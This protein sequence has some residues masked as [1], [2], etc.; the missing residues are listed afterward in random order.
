LLLCKRKKVGTI[1]SISKHD[2]SSA[3]LKFMDKQG[4][5]KREYDGVDYP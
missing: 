2:L 4:R 5:G 3:L 1:A